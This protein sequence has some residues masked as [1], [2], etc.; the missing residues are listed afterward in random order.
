MSKKIDLIFELNEEEKKWWKKTIKKTRNDII[1]T[2]KSYLDIYFKKHQP[3]LKD[4]KSNVS[5]FISDLREE[6]WNIYLHDEVR[7]H[8]K[9]ISHLID[10][11]KLPQNI[12]NAI[13]EDNLLDDG[14]PIIN[15]HNIFEKL[16]KVVGDFAGRIMPYL[17]DLS[18]STTNSRRSRAGSTFE[19]IVERIL[20]QYEYPFEN[21]SSLGNKF[22]KD[23]DLGKMVDIVVPHKQ[24][25]ESNRSKCIIIT[26]K[27]TLRERWQEVVEELDR[28]NIPHIYLMTLDR[29]LNA[30][31]ILQMKQHNITIVTYDDIKKELDEYDNVMLCCFICKIKLAFK[32]KILNVCLPA[33]GTSLQN[34]HTRLILI[35]NMFLAI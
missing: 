13:I 17:Y 16:K 24:A 33:N 12:L 6:C 1:G 15:K 32:L 20:T 23:N 5:R 9:I 26:M 2:P 14:L 11:R 31:L 10:K 3:S 25:Y 30:N 19:G 4:I 8:E 22:Y 34:K 28:T 18:L 35:T 21:Q 7:F 29:S 27:T